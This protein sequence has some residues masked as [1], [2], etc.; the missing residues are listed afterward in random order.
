MAKFFVGQRVRLVKSFRGNEGLTGKI[1]TTDLVG[2]ASNWSNFDCLV[3]WDDGTRDGPLSKGFSGSATRFWQLEP[4]LDQHQ[5]CES[6]FKE[7]LDKLLDG[8]PA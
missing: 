1:R 5:P 3:N 6:E 2:L 4:I 7:S 8:L